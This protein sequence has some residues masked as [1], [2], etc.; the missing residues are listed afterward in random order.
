MLENN[1]IENRIL[2]VVAYSKPRHFVSFSSRLYLYA[3]ANDR[4]GISFVM[5][6]PRVV[7]KS[8]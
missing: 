7:L 2:V 4:I 8:E 6:G 5:R 1:G 3:F